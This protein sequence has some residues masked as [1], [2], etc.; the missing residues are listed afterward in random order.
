MCSARAI[1]LYST[2]MDK[3]ETHIE[4][5]IDVEQWINNDNRIKWMANVCDSFVQKPRTPFY[6]HTHM[7]HSQEAYNILL[8][9][10]F[11]ICF[12]FMLF[13]WAM[14]GDEWPA[15]K[16]QG[17]Q[18][19][20]GNC[21]GRWT[22]VWLNAVASTPTNK[23]KKKNDKHISF[24]MSVDDKK[25]FHARVK[26][27]IVK[28]KSFPTS[29]TH[30]HSLNRKS[31]HFIFC[32][33]HSDVGTT[34]N[35]TEKERKKKKTSPRIELERIFRAAL[36]IYSGRAIFVLLLILMYLYSQ[37]VSISLCSSCSCAVY[38]FGWFVTERL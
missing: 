24:A 25:I 11:I 35:N 6:R 1:I 19:E 18:R 26:L 37:R 17:L 2:L 10:F 16:G 28:K 30:T 22:L 8:L 27:A 14:C 12:M 21:R 4:N 33:S 38:I 15:A 7:F 9:C 31:V 3:T 5:E 13:A 34:H 23:Q 36:L 32:C 29:H 20:H